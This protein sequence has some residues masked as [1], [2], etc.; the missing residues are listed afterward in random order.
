M[1]LNQ[2]NAGNNAIFGS[3]TGD[4][5]P[6]TVTQD[7]F[8]YV[9]NITFADQNY[10]IA[11]DPGGNSL[12]LGNYNGVGT[13]GTPGITANVSATIAAPI[14]LGAPQQ[15]W[16]IAAGQVLTISGPIAG[17]Y[18]LTAGRQRHARVELP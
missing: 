1:P 17:Q 13:P 8:V 4:T 18:G 11:A 3:G 7:G 15:H 2:N 5:N 12:L 6:Y 14:T 9:N 16:T 10:T